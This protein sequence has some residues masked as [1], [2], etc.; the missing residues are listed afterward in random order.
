MS[1]VDRMIVCLACNAVNRVPADKSLASAKCGKCSAALG[2]PHPVEI[3]GEQLRL[4]EAKDTGAFVLDLWAP[5]CG[6]CRAM[7]PAYDAAAQ[8]LYEHVRFFKLNTDQNQ[9]DAGRM[10]LRGIPTL[11]VWKGGRRVANQ[12]GAQT[13]PALE[14]WVRSAC[15]LTSTPN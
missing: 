15:N 3:S 13:G 11:M 1:Q 4:L 9:A 10:Q 7:A 6:P 2:T 5:W 14:R 8:N 12:P